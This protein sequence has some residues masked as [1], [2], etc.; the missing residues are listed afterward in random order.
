M[1]LYRSFLNGIGTG[2]GVAWPFFG[3][4]FAVLGGSVGGHTSIVLGIVSITLF[5]VV[6]GI[7][8]YL[9]YQDMK[10]SEIKFQQLVQKNKRKLMTSV[11]SYLQNIE[12]CYFAQRTVPNFIIYLHSIIDTDLEKV[13]RDDLNSPLYKI[14]YIISQAS[15]KNLHN[16]LIPNEQL[17]FELITNYIKQTTSSPNIYIIPAF[18]AF[19]G[20]FGSIAGCCAGISGLLTGLGVFTSFTAFPII[21]LGIIAI[22]S[23]CG[24]AIAKEAINNAIEEYQAIELNI[25]VKQ[26][27]QQ[28]KKA[29]F[30][31][32]LDCALYEASSNI[33]SNPEEQVYFYS[34]INKP[35]EN[36]LQSNKIYNNATHI[37]F[38]PLFKIDTDK[39]NKNSTTVYS[40]AN[41]KISSCNK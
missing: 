16:S 4:V 38:I 35:I 7:I 36:K 19:V 5:L 33:S 1:I 27:Y 18:S 9:S 21:G 26:M 34:Q 17:L 29:N 37:K 40:I 11:R 10:N 39:T 12:E 6:S 41:T 28:L 31:R 3:V 8:F 14:L 24:L 25:T 32:E 30:V 22:A 15:Q 23:I 2:A 13:S 20:T